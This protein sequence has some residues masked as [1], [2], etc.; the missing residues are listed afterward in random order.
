MIVPK[1]AQ[2]ASFFMM[3]SLYHGKPKRDPIN[4]ATFVTCRRIVVK[5]INIGLIIYALDKY[6]ISKIKVHDRVSIRRNNMS[7]KLFLLIAIVA[8]A[9]ASL[10]L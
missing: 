5:V 6:C 3:C 1:K 7:R 4:K 9:F 8:L 2:W 10:G